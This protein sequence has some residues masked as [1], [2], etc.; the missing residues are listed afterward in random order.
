[1][2][3]QLLILLLSFG[4]A[5]L[6]TY[7]VAQRMMGR[8]ADGKIRDRLSSD[9]LAGRGFQFARVNQVLNQIGEAAARPFM[10]EDQTKQ[11][12]IRRN[13]ARAGI[14]TPSGIRMFA[15]AKVLCLAG[16]LV[17]GYGIGAVVG[18]TFLTLSLGGLAG[19][20][21]PLFWLKL[22]TKSNQL[23]LNNGL[24]DALDLMVVCVEAGL[25]IDSA[26]LRIG[27]E[28]GIAQPAISREM[29]LAHMETRVGLSRTE[30]MRNMGLRTGNAALQSLA[31]MLIQADRFGTSIADALRIHSETLRTNRQMAAEE[32]AGKA[33]VKMSFPLVLCIFPSTFIVLAGPT[34]LQLMKS[35]IFQ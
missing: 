9:T 10:P 24:A 19:Y 3:D 26:M 2:I 27:Q 22:K 7:A 5:A 6:L 21:L 1:M 12:V 33:S 17:L 16:G 4:S 32:I 15:A 29:S 18:F 25:T 14:Y 11:I 35:S 13:L 23:A 20:L 34:I 30:A 31:S 28:L 8:E